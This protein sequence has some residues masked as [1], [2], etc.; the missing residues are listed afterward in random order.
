MKNYYRVLI[1]G[2]FALAT[3]QLK[4][5]DVLY[6]NDDRDLKVKVIEITDAAVK[7]KKFDNQDGP[8]YSANINDVKK[9][10]YKNGSEDV[11]EH[12]AKPAAEEPAEIKPASDGKKFDPNDP[13]TN[14]MLQAIAKNAGDKLLSRCTGKVDNSTTEIFFDQIYKDEF[15]GEINL[16]IIIKWDKGL[17]NKQRWIKGIVKIDKQGKKTW[18]YQNDSGILFSGCAKTMLEF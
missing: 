15:S 9:V 1:C 18:M 11:F 6:F 17:A 4:A 7:Y 14:D 2:A 10:K 16:P 8:S 12:K 13:D 3:P 5:Q